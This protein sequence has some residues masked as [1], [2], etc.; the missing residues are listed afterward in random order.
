MTE[1]RYYCLECEREL[2]VGARIHPDEKGRMEHTRCVAIPLGYVSIGCG[3]V[4]ERLSDV[5][6]DP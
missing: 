2:P 3:P 4:E 6:A 5:E 1:V